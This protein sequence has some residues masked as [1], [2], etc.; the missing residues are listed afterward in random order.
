MIKVQPRATARKVTVPSA[1]PRSTAEAHA[2]G[3]GLAAWW[4]PDD[5]TVVVAEID[6]AGDGSSMWTA[7]AAAFA[8]ALVA[9]QG[10]PLARR[11]EALCDRLSPFLYERG[12]YARRWR[13][14][15]AWSAAHGGAHGDWAD[16]GTV[17][18]DEPEPAAPPASG[19]R[20]RRDCVVADG[21]V[22]AKSRSLIDKQ[23]AVAC[24]RQLGIAHGTAVRLADGQRV[25]RWTIAQARSALG[26][27]PA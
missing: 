8:A 2:R 17:L 11:Y 15:A 3:M 21:A 13:T 24:S 18:D 5:A 26:M 27:S 14:M 19:R 20:A 1:D 9:V 16:M 22:R 7:D 6:A 10:E 4:S 25:N 12:S 23:G